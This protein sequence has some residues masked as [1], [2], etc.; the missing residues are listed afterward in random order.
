M[1]AIVLAWFSAA[2]TLV[3]LI[4]GLAAWLDSRAT[5][6]AALEH[7]AKGLQE[8][9]IKVEDH[10]TRINTL[11]VEHKNRFNDRRLETLEILKEESR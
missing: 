6:K 8:M 2:S 5:L 9:Q 4:G 3:L 7:F 1:T 11:E 10:E